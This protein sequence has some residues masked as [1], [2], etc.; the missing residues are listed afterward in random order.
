MKYAFRFPQRSLHWVCSEYPTTVSSA[1]T[2]W[3]LTLLPRRYPRGTGGRPVSVWP[4]KLA[5]TLIRNLGILG[6]NLAGQ[7]CYS[8]KSNAGPS[9]EFTRILLQAGVAGNESARSLDGSETLNQGSRLLFMRIA[10]HG[11]CSPGRV[12][13]D[14]D[15]D[16]WRRART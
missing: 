9:I 7:G 16:R 13:S 10:G 14:R 8:Q 4:K 15:G 5:R 3:R 6:L 12:T 1:L 2:V 11:G